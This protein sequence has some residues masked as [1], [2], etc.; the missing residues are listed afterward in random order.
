VDHIFVP[1]LFPQYWQL[2]WFIHMSTQR[3]MFDLVLNIISENDKNQGKNRAN[4][5]FI[6]IT[7]KY[8]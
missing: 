4:F 8:C 3:K 1:T 6:A 2:A 7:N 5:Y